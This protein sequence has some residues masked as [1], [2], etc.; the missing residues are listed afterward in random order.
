MSLLGKAGHSPAARE[1]GFAA[2]RAGVDRLLASYRAIPADANV[3]LAKKTSNLF[4]ARAKNTAPG[5]DVSGLTQ[6]VA[7]DPD[8]RTA[9]V[10]GMTTY[11]DL[12]AATL[13]Y[14]LAPLVV[15]QLKTITLG[16]AVTG[17]GI[18]S[19]SFRSGLPHESVLEMD[20][21]TGAGELITARPDGEHAGLFRG[22]P[23]SYG[24]LG[25]T[26]RLKI[27]LEPVLPYVALRHVRFRDLRELEA[28]ITRIVD[29]KSYD[30]ERVDY[31]DGVVFT[32]EESYLTLGR[33][34][35]EP[36]PVSDYTGMDIYYRSIQHDGA[37]P[38]RDRL[39]IHDYLW[40]WDTD[41][42]WCSRAFGTQNP[43]I[44]RFWP[45]RYRRSSFYWKLVALDHKYD[46][47]DKLEARKGNPP[48]ERVVQDIEVPVERTADFVEWFLRE[49]PIEP[50][51]LCPLRLRETA[52]P[53]ATG[54][55]WPLYPIEPNRTYVNVGFW[56][57]VPTVPG[58][59]EGAANRAIERTV[60]EFDGHKSLYS[61]AYYEKDE[62]AALYGGQTYTELKKRYDPDQRL[63]DLYS[64]AVQRK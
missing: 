14:G 56:S 1:S 36:G 57:A 44:R 64:K 59:Q 42:F 12:V 11:E 54:R 51:W 27:E 55:P 9:D 62:F 15:P 19:T 63:L 5:L 26:V 37:R 53:A 24:T 31:L 40:R 10:A 8:A 28:A 6:V 2:H 30:G 39:T 41:W 20:V 60:T 4:R 32:A 46:I 22:F 33:Q 13:P 34:T 17:L 16:G 7:V 18:E 50:I 61:D 52:A 47:G 23:N 45:K 58:Q 38:K 3:R 49:I 29:E 43:R 25:Y 35:D 48:R 21:L